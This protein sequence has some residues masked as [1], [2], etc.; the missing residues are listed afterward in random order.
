MAEWSLLCQRKL[1]KTV[2]GKTAW[3]CCVNAVVN[4]WQMFVGCGVAFTVE[5]SEYLVLFTREPPRTEF[6]RGDS[7]GSKLRH[8]RLS[9]SR[10]VLYGR[11]HENTSTR[12]MR[13]DT[14]SD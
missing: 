10:E 12:E 4:E 13:I 14:M 11:S 5:R 8:F 6:F 3:W 9:L 1:L 7:Q 2:R